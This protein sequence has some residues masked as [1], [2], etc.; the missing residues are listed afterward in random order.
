MRYWVQTILHVDEYTE[1]KVKVNLHT[2]K[3]VKSYCQ[4]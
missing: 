2:V 1:D 4:Y 3:F